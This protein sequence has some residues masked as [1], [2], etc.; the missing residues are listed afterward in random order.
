MKLLWIGVAS[1]LKAR[2]TQVRV[3][4]QVSL[5]FHRTIALMFLTFYKLKFLCH[6]VLLVF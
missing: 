2:V 6:H 4:G 1:I 3:L 5:V